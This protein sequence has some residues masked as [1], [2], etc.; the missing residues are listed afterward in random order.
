[1]SKLF[2][3]FSALETHIRM[4]KVEFRS[5]SNEMEEFHQGTCF[6]LFPLTLVI[7]ILAVH[8]YQFSTMRWIVL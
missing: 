1:M 7:Y 8:K 5:E 2:Y 6:C 3:F 4:V